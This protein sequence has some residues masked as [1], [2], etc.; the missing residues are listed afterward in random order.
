MNMKKLISMLLA[1]A[2]LL[3]CAALGEAAVDYVGTWMLTGLEAGGM[4][5]DMTMLAQMGMDMTMTINEDGTMFT[6]SMGVTE[7]GTWVVTEKG[8]AI[9]DD[10]E[11]IEIACENDVL[12]IEEEGAAMLLTRE[13]AAPAVAPAAVET[14][15]AAA[16]FAA[17]WVLSSVEIGGESRDAAEL[18]LN[19]Y[20]E[21]Y[22][23][24]YCVMVMDDQ[25]QEGSWTMT[26][27]GIQTTDADGVVE[28]MTYVDGALVVEQD[29][30]KM[31]F[32]QE[33]YAAPMSGL[34]AADFDGDWVFSYVEV[35][36]Q[37]YDAAEIGMEIEL[38][39]SEGKGH[40][41]MTFS[42]GVDEFDAVC[43]VEEIPDFGTA[44]YL[45]ALGADGQP[46]GTG[47]ILLMFDNGELV[48]YER[49]EDGE[50]FYCFVPAEA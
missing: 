6:T 22:D 39:I 14:S 17:Y 30:V 1:L 49:D 25:M 27:T 10:E 46:D 3:S 18:G 2:M 19:A 38:H 32:V 4:M 34:T 24:G 9:T 45:L 20:M 16:D 42:D 33:T 26:E 37:M 43:E 8:I 15:P 36:G 29:G 44:M 28:S 47:M 50:Y 35:L 40:V 41:K 12:R 13:G 23:D 11:T 5:W 21:L 7:N 31:I 48:W